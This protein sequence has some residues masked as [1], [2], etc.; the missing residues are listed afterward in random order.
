VRLQG[1]LSSDAGVSQLLGEGETTGLDDDD[2]L[3]R[4]GEKKKRR[5]EEEKKKRR[6]EEIGGK[7]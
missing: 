6:K 2:G 3:M 4:R 7:F 1:F 5:R